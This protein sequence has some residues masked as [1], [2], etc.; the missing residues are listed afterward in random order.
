MTGYTQS[1][2]FERAQKIKPLAFLEK[3]V[4]IYTLKPVIDSYFCNKL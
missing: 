3:P 1:G 2:I 4:E